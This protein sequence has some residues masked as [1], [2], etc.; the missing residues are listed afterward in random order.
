M[1]DDRLT[2]HCTDD[3]GVAL[4][5]GALWS[6]GGCAWVLFAV[7]KHDNFYTVNGYSFQ[8]FISH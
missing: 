4:F 5:V 1:V 8:W 2:G 3:V 6:L 7:T